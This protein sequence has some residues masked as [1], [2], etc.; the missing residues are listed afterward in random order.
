MRVTLLAAW[1]CDV[2]ASSSAAAIIFIV[3]VIIA[4]FMIWSPLTLNEMVAVLECTDCQTRR[5]ARRLALLKITD[6]AGEYSGGLSI[7]CQ[8]PAA[9]QMGK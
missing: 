8:I 1:S 6:A 5:S 7:L 2:K 9:A 3:I 4:N